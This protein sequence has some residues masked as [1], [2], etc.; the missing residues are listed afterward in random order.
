M[1]ETDLADGYQDRPVLPDPPLESRGEIEVE[2]GGVESRGREHLRMKL[3]EPSVAKSILQR[4][5]HDHDG[6]D[7]GRVSPVQDLPPVCVEN[8]IAQVRVTVDQGWKGHGPS[9]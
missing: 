4:L 2:M 6:L 7:A 8:R 9:G 5:T 1:I 3:G